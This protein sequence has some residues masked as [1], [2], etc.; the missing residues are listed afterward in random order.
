MGEQLTDDRRVIEWLYKTGHFFSPEVLQYEITEANLSKLNLKHPAVKAAVHSLQS[1]DI[2]IEYL[3][4]KHHGR[5]ALPDGDVGPATRELM[6]IPRCEV[7][8]FFAPDD[9]RAAIVG[10]GSWPM[11]C[12]KEGIKLHIN[13]SGMP[14]S[15]VA[16]WTTIKKQFINA[17][18]MMGGKLVEVENENEANI[19]MFFGSFFGGVI[20][21]AEFNSQSC[22]DIVT[23]KLSNSYSQQDCGLPKHELGHNFNLGHTRGGTMNPSI[24]RELDAEGKWVPADPSYS[25]LKGFLGGNPIDDFPPDFPPPPPPSPAPTPVPT[26]TPTPTPTTWWEKLLQWFKDN[27]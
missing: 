14:S 23:C 24:L 22:S 3:S 15:V 19:L 21:L 27:W 7:P 9:P 25:T 10:S 20:G 5:I 8:D 2:N 12:Q 16:K 6:L 18:A 4:V 26:P 1:L 17:Y 13:T 11:P